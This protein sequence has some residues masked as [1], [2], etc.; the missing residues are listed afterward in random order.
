ME[1]E[2]KIFENLEAQ[3]DLEC[4]KLILEIDEKKKNLFQQEEMSNRYRQREIQTLGMRQQLK[5]ITEE[6][7]EQ[8]R[9]KRIQKW[10]EF[11]KTILRPEM[12]NG[13]F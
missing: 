2:K 4:R 7:W 12:K 13:K 3:I 8:G 5:E 10:R 9:E 11:K 6:Q 1:I